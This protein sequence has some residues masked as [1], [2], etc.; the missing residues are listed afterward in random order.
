MQIRLWKSNGVS[1][2]PKAYLFQDREQECLFIGSFN[3]SKSALNQ[4]VEWNL[5]VSNDQQVFAEALDQFL[6]TFY[7]DQTISLN[8]ETLKDYKEKYK[9]YH[10]KNPN[11]AKTWSKMEELGLMLP[12]QK[13]EPPFQEVIKNRM[14]PGT[15]I[16]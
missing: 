5:S 7:A 13:D 6:T 16:L 2:H 9:E 15:F 12:T 10:Q 11:L 14:V 4:G 1:F 8:K 3:L